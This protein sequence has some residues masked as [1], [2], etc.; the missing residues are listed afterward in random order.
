VQPVF[1]V[2]R[3]SVYS[4]VKNSQVYIC[5][6]DGRGRTSGL[7]YAMNGCLVSY[8]RMTDDGFGRGRALGEFAESARWMLLG[9]EDTFG[10]TNDGFFI[11]IT[12]P[13]VIDD[14]VSDR[15]LG[16]SNVLFLDGHVK[17]L[18]PEVLLGQRYH[19]GGLVT[20][21]CP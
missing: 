16:G 9:E 5:P 20:P 6:S 19:T 14:T 12:A 13:L 18:R 8:D 7:T 11:N 17:W 2:A 10:S 1:D 21:N 3:G 15:H 4:Y